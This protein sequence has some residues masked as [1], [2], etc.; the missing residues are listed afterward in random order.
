MDLLK[1]LPIEIQGKIKYFVIEHPVARIFKD[2]VEVNIKNDDGKTWIEI[3]IEGSEYTLDFT[4]TERE[5]DEFDRQRLI[6][7]E[8]KIQNYKREV[9]VSIDWSD[10]DDDDNDDGNTGILSL[11]TSNNNNGYDE[12]DY[13][14]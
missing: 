11:F 12:I 4:T 13:D 6:M 7:M 1:D 10:S 2:N 9:T 5:Y 3:F 14:D 8:N